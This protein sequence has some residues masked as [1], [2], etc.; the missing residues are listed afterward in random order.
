MAPQQQ[1]WL[2]PGW[3][4]LTT[5]LEPMDWLRDRYPELFAEGEPRRSMAQF[6][7]LLCIQYGLVDHRALAFFELARDASTEFALRLH[8]DTRL[9]ER[10]AAVFDVSL[11]EFDAAAPSHLRDAHGFQGG[12]IDHG[13]AA[14]VLEHGS[15]R[16]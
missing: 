7:M 8:R 2:S 9:R 13:A 10:I 3:E 15:A 4:F 14:N 16:L 12:V 11:E 5:S 1:R 6:D